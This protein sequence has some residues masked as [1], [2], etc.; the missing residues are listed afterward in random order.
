MTQDDKWSAEDSARVAVG[1][2]GLLILLNAVILLVHVTAPLFG[3]V[4]ILKAVLFYGG[5]L[6]FL[7][8]ARLKLKSKYIR[9]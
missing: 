9:P 5:V 7:F 4:Y 3:G 8:A 2:F 6:I 1:L